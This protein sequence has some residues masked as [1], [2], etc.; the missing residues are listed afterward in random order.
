MCIRTGCREACE[1]GTFWWSAA[2]EVHHVDPTVS[3]LRFACHPFLPAELLSLSRTAAAAAAAS[4]LATWLVVPKMW[5]C[6]VLRVACLTKP[7]LALLFPFPS[8][9]GFRFALPVVLCAC[10]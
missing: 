6:C 4:L 5:G 8:F 2:D 10:F 9:P 7:A 1:A 3:T